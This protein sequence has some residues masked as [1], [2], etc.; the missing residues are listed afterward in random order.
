MSM[1][2]FFSVVL[3][4]VHLAFFH[5]AFLIHHFHHFAHIGKLLHQA[6]YL[7]FTTL[8]HPN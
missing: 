4:Y 8:G 3:P 1:L 6:V 2:R 7:L 5:T